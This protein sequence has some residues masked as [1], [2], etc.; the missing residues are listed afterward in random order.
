MQQ[1]QHS[2]FVLLVSLEM[3]IT[4]EIPSSTFYVIRQDIPYIMPIFRKYS[5]TIPRASNPRGRIWQGSVHILSNIPLS[6]WKSAYLTDFLIYRYLYNCDMIH[7]MGTSLICQRYCHQH[8][9]NCSCYL[10]F[11]RP[12]AWN[13]EHT[14]NFK[15]CQ[16]VSLHRK[17]L[18]CMAN[19]LV[20]YT[21][22][23]PPTTSSRSPAVEH[24]YLWG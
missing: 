17:R 15:R 23:R 20:I 10:F 4:Q 19:R 9:L 1:C 11:N 21:K 24:H 8:S 12:A 14:G 22:P 3:K 5:P 13:R 2:K 6:D 18:S 7:S 16:M